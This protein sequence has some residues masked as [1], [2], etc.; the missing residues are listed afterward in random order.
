ME[1]SRRVVHR[2]WWTL[3]GLLI[4]AF[5]INVVGLLLCFVGWIVAAPVS[6]AALDVRLRG[7]VRPARQ[8]SRRS[9]RPGASPL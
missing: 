3:F 2:Q 5:L 4:V 1:V 8:R 9:E 6:I 7:S